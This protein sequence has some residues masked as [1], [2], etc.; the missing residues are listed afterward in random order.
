MQRTLQDCLSLSES[1]IFVLKPRLAHNKGYAFF[2]CAVY[3]AGDDIMS[4]LNPPNWGRPW[5]SNEPSGDIPRKVEVNQTHS[6]SNH[7]HDIQVRV[8]LGDAVLEYS[9]VFDYDDV[10]GWRKV[11]SQG[12]ACLRRA[13]HGDLRQQQESRRYEEGCTHR[14]VSGNCPTHRSCNYDTQNPVHE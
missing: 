14:E 12:H 10:S 1:T 2:I 9:D 11:L 13:A 7:L 5:S 4:R 6:S 3:L 8:F